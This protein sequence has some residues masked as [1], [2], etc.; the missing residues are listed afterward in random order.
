MNETFIIT[1]SV[2]LFLYPPPFEGISVIEMRLSVLQSIVSK[3]T[4]ENV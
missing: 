1:V 2:C 3:F 4:F